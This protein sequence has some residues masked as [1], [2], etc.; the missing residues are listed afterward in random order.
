MMTQKIFI[1]VFLCF[2]FLTIVPQITAKERSW[3][4]GGGLGV[5]EIESDVVLWPDLS[6]AYLDKDERQLGYKVF[7]GYRLN[8][9]IGI[10]I[11]YVDF[12]KLEVMGNSGAGFASDGVVWIFNQNNSKVTLEPQTFGIG[13]NFSLPL[14][15]VTETAV[16]KKLT[17]FFKI[18]A[19][20]WVA[21]KSLTPPNSANFYTLQYPSIVNS[22][23]HSI[24]DESGLNFFY[25][26]GISFDVN[27]RIEISLS[28]EWFNFDDN[29][30][31]DADFISSSILIKF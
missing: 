21:D 3:Y 31:Q 16:I 15:K 17:P 26:A 29:M 30:A 13:I 19:H 6:T 20:Y 9:F 11:L 27:S 4:L 22:V 18:G 10:E 28:Y 2:L 8:D 14:R 7:G 1:S 24:E 23:N 12:G 5:T 25:G